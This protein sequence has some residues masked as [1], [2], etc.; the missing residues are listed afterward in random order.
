MH[1]N[2]KDCWAVVPGA[3]KKTYFQMTAFHQQIHTSATL[4]AL[5]ITDTQ[6]GA[7]VSFGQ[8]YI[9]QPIFKF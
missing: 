6:K 4:R 2:E 5:F 3:G 9:F 8:G 7:K 1:C